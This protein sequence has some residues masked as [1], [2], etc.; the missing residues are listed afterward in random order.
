M[1]VPKKK[2]TAC[3]K[4]MNAELRRC[5]LCGKDQKPYLNYIMYI[6][7]IALVFAF[8]TTNNGTQMTSDKK[9]IIPTQSENFK[10]SS[11]LT[12]PDTTPEESFTE[13]YNITSILRSL[14]Q[15]ASAPDKNSFDNKKLDLEEQL[16][17]Q[18]SMKS[19]NE[20][21][22]SFIDLLFDSSNNN[23]KK[24]TA[25]NASNVAGN[26]LVSLGLLD[27]STEYK[28]KD[29]FHKSLN[30]DMNRGDERDL[31]I[32]S[33]YNALDFSDQFISHIISK[34]DKE[35]EDEVNRQ[36]YFFENFNFSLETLRTL[37][38]YQFMEISIED[39]NKGIAESKLLTDKQIKQNKQAMTDL[40]SDYKELY[41][42][43]DKE[44]QY[45]QNI[46]LEIYKDSG[47]E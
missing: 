22:N 7:A 35:V 42:L 28:F 17:Y 39:Y 24:L 2:C 32:T 31:M 41:N 25:T 45:F 12:K 46:A 43:T 30:A 10:L 3:N 15:F 27:K 13:K 9:V 16:Q 38:P 4:S 20:Q 11:F 26:L 19:N 33:L 44:A 29:L 37:K 5:P 14:L 40:F 21:N 8:L 1:A 6:G 34:T 18:V 47:W 36:V 23:N